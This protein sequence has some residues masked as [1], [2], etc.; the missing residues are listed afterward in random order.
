VKKTA[1]REDRVV[2]FDIVPQ[3]RQLTVVFEDDGYTAGHAGE[4]DDERNT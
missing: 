1:I 4:R 3:S 2:D